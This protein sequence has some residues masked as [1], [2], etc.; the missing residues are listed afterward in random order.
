MNSFV[1][2]SQRGCVGLEEGGCR[3]AAEK[4]CRVVDE[5]NLLLNISYALE[6][7]LELRDVI[8]PVLLKMEAVMD[9]SAA[10]LPSSTAKAAVYRLPRPSDCRASSQRKNISGIIAR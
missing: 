10:R 6:S 7:S 1:N 4:G 3:L 8:R 2:E 9:F 5:L